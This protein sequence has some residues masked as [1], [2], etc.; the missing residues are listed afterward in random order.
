MA[1]LFFDESLDASAFAVGAVVEL[2]GAEAHHAATVNRLRAGERVSVG[3]GRGT[4]AQ[5]VVERADREALSVRVESVTREPEP[6]PRIVL[7]QAL[8]K[9]DRD[10]LAIQAACEVGVDAVVPWQAERSVSVWKGE[11]A[12]RG[13]ERWRAIVREAAKQSLRA[14]VP[15]VR[16]LEDAASLRAHTALDPQAVPTLI[17]EPTAERPLSEVGAALAERLAGLDEVVLVVGP[18]G[19]I[20]P[21]ELGRLTEAGAIGVRLGPGVLRTS[22]AGPVAIALLQS[23]LGRW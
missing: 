8:A 22:T 3:D 6:S 13:V 4:L 5:A 17:L 1:G 23:I 11:K 2:R 15:E 9:G 20:S 10:E 16:A 18:E 19:G 12:S 14:R 7:V 21:A